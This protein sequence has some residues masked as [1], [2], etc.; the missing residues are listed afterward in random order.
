ML[1][2]SV[3]W[4]CPGPWPVMNSQVFHL[5]PVLMPSQHQPH[6]VQWW[7]FLWCL[8]CPE[9][10]ARHI[11]FVVSRTKTTTADLLCLDELAVIVTY[12]AVVQ[13]QI[14][15]N[16]SWVN[17]LHLIST[18]AVGTIQEWSRCNQGTFYS[19]YLGRPVKVY[20]TFT[21]S[22]CHTTDITC[23]PSNTVRLDVA[24]YRW[25]DTCTCM[26][27]SHDHSPYIERI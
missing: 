20:C 10:I 18:I 21:M 15:S 12:S 3:H 8:Q 4:L 1:E 27:T 16:S 25:S 14:W 13:Y 7:K 24:K 2:T 22:G 5:E 9:N 11:K 17:S 6:T 23:C 19:H 26:C